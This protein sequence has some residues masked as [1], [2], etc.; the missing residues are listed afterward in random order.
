[1]HEED[2]FPDLRYDVDDLAPKRGIGKRGIIEV[3][4]VASSDE[5]LDAI[6]FVFIDDAVT[7][8]PRFFNVQDDIVYLYF[9][10]AHDF[11][12]DHIVFRNLGKRVV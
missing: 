8:E 7:N 4:R 11:R 10:I 5:I 3:I 1:M 2:E 9:L 12:G 6:A